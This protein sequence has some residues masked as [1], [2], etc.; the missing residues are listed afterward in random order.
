[1]HI[2]SGTVAQITHMAAIKAKIIVQHYPLASSGC[3][4]RQKSSS[5]PL[6]DG[7]PETTKHF[8]TQCLTLEGAS[9]PYTRKL[10][11]EV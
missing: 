9:A 10:L 4:G 7:P 6:W 8:L 11:D 1:M 5:C 3:A 2:M